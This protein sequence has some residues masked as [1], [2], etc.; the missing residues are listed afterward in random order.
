MELFHVIEDGAV[1]L[2]V[3]GG[4]YK[5]AK[6]F[7]RGDQVYAGVGGDTFVRLMRGGG[8]SRPSISWL[9]I[10]GPGISTESGLPVWTQPKTKK[11][12]ISAVAA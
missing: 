11:G 5:Q 8:T 10:E 3:A 6:I 4:T 2:K 7:R 9:E 1:I 12:K